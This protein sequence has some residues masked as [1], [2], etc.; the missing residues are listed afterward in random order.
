LPVVGPSPDPY[1]PALTK[2]DAMPTEKN[3]DPRPLQSSSRRA[4]L[5][6]AVIAILAVAAVAI[7]VSRG[8]PQAA[9]P[10]SEPS[11]LSSLAVTTT[12]TYVRTEVVDRLREILRIRDR[13]YRDRN[14]DVLETIYT[15]DCPCLKGDQSAIRQLL[16]DDAVWVG[17]STS[18][19]VKKLERVNDRLWIVIAV[20]DGSPFRIETESGGLIRSVEGR[21][22]LFRFLVAKN[23]ADP[24]WLLGYAAPVSE[25]K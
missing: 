7:V 21:S 1:H 17:A 10:S 16:K 22:E 19:R 2:R 4:M 13:A 11:T 9:G 18:M 12:T 8:S 3:P 24:E 20:F 23:A 5:A 25:A 15:A 14:A 6:A